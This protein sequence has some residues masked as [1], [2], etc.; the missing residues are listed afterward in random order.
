MDGD[1]PVATI[2]AL[3]ERVRGALSR[4]PSWSGRV[5]TLGSVVVTLALLARALLTPSPSAVPL[6]TPGPAAPA[7]NHYAPEVALLDVSGNRVRLSSLRGNVVVLNFWYASCEPCRRE[8]PTLERAYEQNQ[9]AGLVV[10]GVDI[11]DDAQTMSAFARSIGIT[12][13]IFRDD[14]GH[15][16]SAYQLSAT[17]SS[18][19]IDR[20]GVIRYKIVGPADSATLRQ[21]TAALLATS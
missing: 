16:F 4:L 19:L 13:P 10:V 2:R 17:P 7:I 1:Q 14:Q 18:F 12:Y 20:A 21:D 15:A 6:R 8:M 3:A 9:K 11:A 5:A